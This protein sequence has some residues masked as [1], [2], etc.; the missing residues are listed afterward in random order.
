MKIGALFIPFLVVL[1]P[2]IIVQPAVAQPVARGIPRAEHVKQDLREV[3]DGPEF[4]SLH[5][6]N[7]GMDAFNK[8]LTEKWQRLMEL[9]SGRRQPEVQRPV[10]GGVLLGWIILAGLI[11]GLAYLL[12]YVLKNIGARVK[13]PATKKTTI[14]N[15]EELEESGSIDFDEWLAAATKHAGEGDF[16]R[17]YRA[18][19][20]AILL[21]LDRA[22]RIEYK[23]SRTNGEYLR[24]LKKHPP[25]HHL[26]LPVANA[27]DA[28]WYG[29]VPA[30]ETDYKACLSAYE[31]AGRL[32]GAADST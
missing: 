25:L 4:E 14:A 3:L 27:F 30:T 1:W 6:R 8:W 23:R 9:L 5:R 29:H 13:R 19:F 12:A 24:A 11:V 18:V 17:A 21:Q 28:R 15:V 31:Q 22:G 16:R 32:A 20:V 2:A 7:A 26:V 10:G